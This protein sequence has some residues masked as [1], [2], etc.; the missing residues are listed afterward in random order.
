MPP[1]NTR[2][3]HNIPSPLA[4]YGDGKPPHPQET[5]SSLEETDIFCQFAPASSYV[6]IYCYLYIALP[7]ISMAY[8]DLTT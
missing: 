6:R 4:D 2:Y 8:M 3:I 5:A 7:I 1:C